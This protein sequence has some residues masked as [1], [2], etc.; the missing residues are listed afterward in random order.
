MPDPGPARR[1]VVLKL[2]SL[3]MFSFSLG[4]TML[5]VGG[6]RTSC[7]SYGYNACDYQVPGARPSHPLQNP[8]PQSHLA[9]KLCGRTHCRVPLGGAPPP[10]AS[11]RPWA[12]LDLACPGGTKG[13]TCLQEGS[14]LRWGRD[15]FQCHLPSP[16]HL[17]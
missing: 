5:C 7:E 12:W 1:C 14:S 8:G 2:A 3:G 10:S 13:R 6:N 16:V 15:P 11:C 9:G 4:Q 17:R